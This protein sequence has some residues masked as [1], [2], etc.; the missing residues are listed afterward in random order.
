MSSE[1]PPDDR[2]RPDRAMVL[3]LLAHRGQ[4]IVNDFRLSEDGVTR[5]TVPLVTSVEALGWTWEELGVN[6]TLYGGR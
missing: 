2:K 1:T 3:F 6:P 4:P 5:Q